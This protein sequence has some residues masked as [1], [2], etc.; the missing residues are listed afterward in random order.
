MPKITKLQLITNLCEDAA[1]KISVSSTGSI[2]QADFGES[3]LLENEIYFHNMDKNELIAAI[4]G[5]TKILSPT[6][7]LTWI[8]E[9]QLYLWAWCAQ[10]FADSDTPI[11]HELQFDTLHFMRI[12]THATLSRHNEFAFIGAG[13][14]IGVH[15]RA[16]LGHIPQ[17]VIFL[18]LPLLERLLRFCCREYVD[19]DGK[20]VKA[21]SS[22]QSRKS[23]KLNSRCSNLGHLIELYIA[24]YSL[25]L[26][27]QCA[28]KLLTMLETTQRNFDI[29]SW[30]FKLRNSALHGEKIS[31]NA[32]AIIL[33]ICFSLCL[34]EISS[35]EYE[36]ERDRIYPNAL[37]WIDSN[38]DRPHWSIYP[39]D[40]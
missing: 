4:I 24:Q 5:L 18:T 37:F 36:S 16:V 31:S 12:V 21:F 3:R 1:S 11:R 25:N 17:L 6:P 30:L 26:E 8:N 34:G 28:I 38:S 20:V 22:E 2:T 23:Y 29:A 9:D 35:A 14:N 33:N 40:L 19:F 39:P 10:I 15:S 32:S 13:I 27:K 7:N